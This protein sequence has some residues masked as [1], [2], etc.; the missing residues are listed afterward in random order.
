MSGEHIRLNTILPEQEILPGWVFLR[1]IISQQHARFQPT[2]MQIWDTVV[3]EPNLFG[4]GASFGEQIKALNPLIA[5][6]MDF[7]RLLHIL[8]VPNNSVCEST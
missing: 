1:P 6:V 8:F 2:R 4:G 5:A 3:L 7:L